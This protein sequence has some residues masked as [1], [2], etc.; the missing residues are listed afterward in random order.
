M[1]EALILVCSLTVSAPDCQKNT[2][3]ATF[4]GPEPQESLVGCL[5]HG[6]LYAATSHLVTEGTYSKIVCGKPKT[7][8]KKEAKN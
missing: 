2:A 8:A 4:Y 5:R 7:V 3:I 6:T 1:M